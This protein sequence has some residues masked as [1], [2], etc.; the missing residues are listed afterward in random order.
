MRLAELWVPLNGSSGLT[1]GCVQDTFPEV[2][3]VTAGSLAPPGQNSQGIR[4]RLPLTTGQ[5]EFAAPRTGRIPLVGVTASP[6]GPAPQGASLDL[7]P[8]GFC[9]NTEDLC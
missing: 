9:L 1:G 6:V 5:I 3:G 7:L 2:V 4:S 8:C